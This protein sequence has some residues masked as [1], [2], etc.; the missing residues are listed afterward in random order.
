[1][2]IDEINDLAKQEKE[3]LLRKSKGAENITQ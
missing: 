3:G 1:M 2:T